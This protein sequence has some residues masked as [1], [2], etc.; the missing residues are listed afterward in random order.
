MGRARSGISTTGRV[1]VVWFKVD[2]RLHANRKARIAGVEAMG[3]WVLAASWA[4]EELSD[5]FVPR[6]VLYAW[7]PTAH[8]LAERLE[9][10]GLWV[11]LVHQGEEGWLFHD[12]SEFNPTRDEV[13]ARREA[14]RDKKRKQRRPPGTDEGTPAGT[15]SGR[16]GGTPGTGRTNKD[17]LS[18]DTAGESLGDKTH[19]FEPGR[20]GDCQVCPMPP[21]HR[22]HKGLSIVS[23]GAS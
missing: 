12:W 23:E 8:E 16:P 7:S 11:P 4:A 1:E 5:G 17:L 20:W 9:R 21:R 6:S 13:M 15:D 19:A 18:P 22:V 3:L 10:A 2:D 14:E